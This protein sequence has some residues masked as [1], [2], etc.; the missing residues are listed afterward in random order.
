MGVEEAPT[1]TTTLEL[2]R[3]R[4]A[5]F[6]REV[7]VILGGGVKVLKTRGFSMITY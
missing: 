2:S 1:E 6:H 7:N 3:D 5:R 4:P